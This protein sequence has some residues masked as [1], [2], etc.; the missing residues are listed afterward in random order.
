MQIEN[1]F[2][3]F[4]NNINYITIDFLHYIY[5]CI[6]H[7]RHEIADEQGESIGIFRLPAR[8]LMKIYPFTGVSLRYTIR[9]PLF[10]FDEPCDKFSCRISDRA[11]GYPKDAFCISDSNTLNRHNH[12]F[13]HCECFASRKKIESVIAEDT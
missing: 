5:C 9:F 10:T 6:L 12:I 1:K 13:S 2:A 3:N 7:R 8:H 11:Y 4:A